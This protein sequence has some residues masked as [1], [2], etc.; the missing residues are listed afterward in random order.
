MDTEGFEGHRRVSAGLSQVEGRM[1]CT[2][3]RRCDVLDMF[4]DNQVARFGGKRQEYRGVAGGQRGAWVLGLQVRWRV[5]SNRRSWR[6][7]MAA[8]W[9]ALCPASSGKLLEAW[10][11]SSE[12]VVF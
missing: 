6:S 10:D 8:S 11:K 3:P 7:R 2:K 9:I 4:E 5:E 12:L 1:V